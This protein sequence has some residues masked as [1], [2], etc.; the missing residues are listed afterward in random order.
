MR[1]KDFKIAAQYYDKIVNYIHIDQKNAPDFSFQQNKF[2]KK[3]PTKLKT[4]LA[5]ERLE[6]LAKRFRFFFTDITLDCEANKILIRKILTSLSCYSYLA[7][8]EIVG[9]GEMF[10]GI[11]FI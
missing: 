4:Q 9:A 6:D 1:G 2:Y 10:D 3:L 5:T 7:G 11:Y 8:S